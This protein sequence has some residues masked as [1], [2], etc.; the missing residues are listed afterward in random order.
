MAMRSS[1]VALRRRQAAFKFL[2]VSLGSIV[3]DISETEGPQL[4]F[5]RLARSLRGIAK[6]VKDR[7]SSAESDLLNHLSV[8]SREISNALREFGSGRSKRSI[9][10]KTLANSMVKLSRTFLAVAESLHARMSFGN[11]PQIRKWLDRLDPIETREALECAAFVLHHAALRVGEM[12]GNSVTKTAVPFKLARYSECGCND[13]VYKGRNRR[14]Q[15]LSKNVS[16]LMQRRSGTR[17]LRSPGDSDAALLEIL[18]WELICAEMR[19]SLAKLA[20]Y[21]KLA[22]DFIAKRFPKTKPLLNHPES[23][24]DYVCETQCLRPGFVGYRIEGTD[25]LMLG[26]AKFVATFDV[27]WYFCCARR[28]MVI[29]KEYLVT[30]ASEEVN[31]GVVATT[32]GVAEANAL[33]RSSSIMGGRVPATDPC[34]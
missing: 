12:V 19:R 30:T 11:P 27:S 15:R 34:A 25:S 17:R 4:C 2:A 26:P 1:I 3:V 10:A 33:A 24:W 16:N 20:A 13:T 8:Q 21:L 31:T 18:M 5:A 7:D 29:Y 9:N 23:Y 32:R 14:L 22:A 6:Q 28:C